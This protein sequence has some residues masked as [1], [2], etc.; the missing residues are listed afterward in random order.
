MKITLITGNSPRHKYLVDKFLEVDCEITWVIEDD[1]K[2]IPYK[3]TSDQTLSKLFDLHFEKRENAENEFFSKNAGSKS[4][5][6]IN[7][8]LEIKPKDLSSSKIDNFFKDQNTDILITYGC[9]I[10]PKNLLDKVRM[11]KWN[12]HGGLS[13]KYK[14]TATHFWPT[15]LL[16]P[17]Y[18]GM[19]IHDIT[20]DIDGGGIIHQTSVKLNKQDGIHDNACRTV[21]DFSDEFPK[22]FNKYLKSN[23]SLKGIPQNKS[24]KIWT[25]SMWTP[26]TLKVIY[27]TF[28]DKINDYCIK[29]R[30]IKTPKLISI[31][32]K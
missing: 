6:L 1:E 24:G 25:T 7:K 27:E 4:K 23:L 21:K 9:H 32:D 26:L 28:N 13:P 11:N 15:Y 19:T 22:F 10:L 12:I 30:K 3:D 5:S 20:D 2:K 14:G 29:H 8:I 18:T 31:L 17:E 16:E